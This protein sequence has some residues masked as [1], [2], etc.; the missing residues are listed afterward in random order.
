MTGILLVIS[1][2]S[3]SW[4]TVLAGPAAHWK[5]WAAPP[6]PGRLASDSPSGSQNRHYLN[7]CNKTETRPAYFLV[8]LWHDSHYFAGPSPM[9]LQLYVTAACNP[10]LHQLLTQICLY[11]TTVLR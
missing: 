2:T 1:R 9:Y 7:Y 10:P 5:G 4:F 8:Y 6:G 11:S 3:F